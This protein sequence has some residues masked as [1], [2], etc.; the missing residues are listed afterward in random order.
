MLELLAAGLAGIWGHQTTRNFV[1]RRLRFTSWVENGATWGLMGGA[2]TGIVTAAVVPV[3]PLVG[4][5]AGVLIGT[6]VGIGVGT[7]I[8]VGSSHAR[9]GYL[10]EG[11]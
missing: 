9:R 3:L 2:V 8:A 5:G 4:L 7:G 11:D 6:G 10:P 1:R